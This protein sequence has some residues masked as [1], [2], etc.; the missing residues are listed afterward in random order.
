MRT[1]LTNKNHPQTG[2]NVR[3]DN[4]IKTIITTL[5]YM[6]RQLSGERYNIKNKRPKSNF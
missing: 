3:L 5:F 4:D 1:K 6:F 2:M